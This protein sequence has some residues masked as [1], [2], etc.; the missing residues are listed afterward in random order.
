MSEREVAAS[1]ETIIDPAAPIC[2]AHHHLWDR[3]D[4]RYLL[5]ELLSDL[6]SGHNVTETVYIEWRSHWR[7]AGPE[8]LRP[9]GETEFAAGVAESRLRLERRPC[10]AIVAYADLSLGAEVARVLEAHQAAAPGLFKGIRHVGTWDADPVVR[11]G[12]L[13]SPPGL[14]RDRRFREGFAQLGP[15]RLRFDAWVFQTQLADLIDLAQAFP[16]QTIVLN[17]TGGVLGVGA[18]ADRRQQLFSDWRAGIQELARC[19]NVFMKL[20]GLGMQRSGFP[21][22]G[23]PRASTSAQLEQ[24]WLPWFETCIE[25]FGARRC[26]FESNFPVDGASCSY[27]VLWNTFKRVARRGTPG[28]RQLL[29]RDTARGFYGIA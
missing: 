23:Q 11:G 24:V 10:A 5:P 8:A 7:S 25:E 1:A 22:H 13:I 19:P 16:Q 26:M 17:H 27:A 18:Y 3:P 29:L 6:E 2:D 14:Y 4:Q 20:G 9:V 15:A 28:E 21:F 12:P